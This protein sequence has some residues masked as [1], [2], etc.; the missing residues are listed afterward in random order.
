VLQARTW[1]TTDSVNINFNL[2]IGTMFRA[3]LVDRLDTPVFSPLLVEYTNMQ[4]SARSLHILSI[5]LI[6]SLKP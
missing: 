5:T 1:T 3:R 4:I 6:D 2:H